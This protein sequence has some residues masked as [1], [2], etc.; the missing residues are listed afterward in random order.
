[1][2][3]VQVVSAERQRRGGRAEPGTRAASRKEMSLVFKMG[4]F[5]VWLPGLGLR[6]EL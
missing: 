6:V 1:M 5:C 3:L 2:G 4:S